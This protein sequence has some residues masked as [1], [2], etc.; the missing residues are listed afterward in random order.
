MHMAIISEEQFIAEMIPHHQEAVDTSKV[1]LA[2]SNNNDLKNLAEEIVDA[3]TR[4]IEM[5]NSWKKEFYPNSI[6]QSIYLPMMP[7]L[8]DL[9]SPELDNTFIQGMIMHHMMAIMMAEQVL[10]LN[11]RPEIKQFAEQV[12]EVQ[13]KE[14]KQMQAMLVN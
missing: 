10:S 12:I 8:Q 9:K 6:Y 1:I 4:E 13:S 5:L 2:K 14:I 7:N 3:Q 11:P